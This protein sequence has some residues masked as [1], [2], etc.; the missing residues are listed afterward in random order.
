MLKNIRNCLG[1]IRILTCGNGDEINWKYIE[2]LAALQEREGLRLGNSLRKRNIEYRKNIMKEF[3]AAQTLSSSVADAIEFCDQVLNL[4]DFKGSGPTVK[5]I[6]CIDRI[7]DFLN[8]RNPLGKGFKS[9]LRTSNE[10]R[11]RKNILEQINYLS[12]IK[13]HGK[14]IAHSRRK[15]GFLGFYNAELS[16]IDI[17]EK[18]VKSNGPLKYL[19]TYKMSQDHLELFF[20]AIRSRGG[21]CPNPTAAQFVSAY[22]QLMIYHE[23]KNY[24]GNV[25]ANDISILTCASVGS[26]PRYS[27]NALYDISVYG[28]AEYS[29]LELKYFESTENI[30]PSVYDKLQEF[31]HFGWAVPNNVNE[32]TKQCVGYITGFVIR[33]IRNKITCI[34]CLSACESIPSDAISD[35]RNGIALIIQ[36]NRGG[37]IIPSQ[38]V[39]SIYLLV[40]SLF[41]QACKKTNGKPP[42]E[43]K[44]P[45]VLAAKVMKEL[46]PKS[47]TLFPELR[48]HF[49]ETM[50]FETLNSHYDVLIKQIIFKFPKPAL[51]NLVRCELWTKYM[52]PESGESSF[53]LQMKLHN[54]HRILCQKHFN[55]A[56]FTDESKKKLLRTAVPCD[57]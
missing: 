1:D 23:I 11:W 53:T 30:Q 6:R 9:P 2:S 10:N 27:L 47:N 4:P 39:V 16:V 40:E 24:D 48:V 28:Q 51:R 13:L 20:C 34:D 26:R 18:Y 56:D 21:W 41:R 19:L 38:S 3:I 35:R 37:L 55:G 36:K 49:L 25:K 29:R 12:E 45:A 14:P 33:S 43:K 8:V 22:K 52:F 17:Y 32:T 42:V 5:F 54:E 15:A 31:L 7:F 50:M 44:F 57:T 46:L